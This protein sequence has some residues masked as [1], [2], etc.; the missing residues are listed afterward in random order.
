M[1]ED[2]AAELAADNAGVELEPAETVPVLTQLLVIA[3]RLPVA[4][5]LERLM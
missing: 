1:L 3:L 4:A 2:V 5:T